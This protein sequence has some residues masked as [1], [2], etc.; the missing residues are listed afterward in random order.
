MIDLRASLKSFQI[1]LSEFL[2][3]RRCFVIMGM[4]VLFCFYIY[5]PFVR[6][7]HF[8]ESTIPPAVFITYT[9]NYL[10]KVFHSSLVAFMYSSILKLDGYSSWN[11][12]RTGKGN[13]YI[14]Q[15]LYIMVLAVLYEFF[16]FAVVVL[17]ILPAMHINNEWGPFLHQFSANT[18]V[19]AQTVGV[20]VSSGLGE[21][22]MQYL[23]PFQAIALSML[24]LWLTMVFSGSVI[25]MFTVFF[26]RYVGFAAIGILI[27]MLVFC[28]SM[29]SLIMGPV[30][31]KYSPLNWS[32]I[33]ILKWGES[34][35]EVSPLYALAVLS[36]GIIVMFMLSGIKF[37][38]KDTV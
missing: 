8:Y 28:W 35:N 27:M 30:I 2:G 10:M 7:A 29:G 17:F 4:T 32:D 16:L 6:I 1:C 19:M 26:N 12:I 5:I 23:N 36:V 24:Y 22:V 25:M 3:S 38:K 15:C 9:G 21:T 13:Y 11:I 34:G 33:Q 18:V 31:F 20:S 37:M 14:G